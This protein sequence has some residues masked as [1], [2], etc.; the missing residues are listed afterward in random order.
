[1]VQSEQG[2]PFTSSHHVHEMS[3][4][5]L[6]HKDGLR[7][8]IGALIEMG[9]ICPK[10]GIGTRVTSKKWARCKRCKERVERRHLTKP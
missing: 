1:M 7:A 2:E 5:I 9:A 3:F 4:P 6:A 8:M 10:C